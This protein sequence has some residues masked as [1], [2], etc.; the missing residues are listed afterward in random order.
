MPDVNGE[1]VDM[2]VPYMWD[3][4]MPETPLPARWPIARPQ[5]A[6]RMGKLHR[7]EVRQAYTWYIHQLQKVEGLQMLPGCTWCGNPT[8]MFCDY[9]DERPAQAVCTTCCDDMGD[10]VC[11]SCHWDQ[12]DGMDQLVPACIGQLTI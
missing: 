8:G 10:D 6:T 9:C 12:H 11:R 3:G 2:E 5:L 7:P 4:D 1:S